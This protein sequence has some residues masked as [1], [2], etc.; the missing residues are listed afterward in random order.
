MFKNKKIIILGMARSGYEVAKLLAKY[1]NEITINDMNKDEDEKRVNELEKLGVEVILGS[2]PSNLIDS[3]IDYLIKNPGIHES[4][5]YVQKCRELG[6]PVLT[7]IEVAYHF[8]PQ[9]VFI[10]GI[11]GTNGKTTTTSLIYD[12]L[13][14]SDYKA[15]LAGNIGIPLSAMVQ[16][17]NSGDILVIEISSQQLINVDK[18]K[19]NIGI[20]TNLSE[21]HLDAH[22]TYEN[23][24][25]TKKKIFAHHTK[26]DIGIINFDNE[27][28]LELTEDIESTKKYFSTKE[29]KDAYLESNKIYIGDQ[30]FDIKDIKLI[31]KHNYENIMAALLV[32]EQLKI[33]SSLIKETLKEFGGVEHRMEFVR[34]INGI[35]FYNDSKSTNNVATITAL[36]S[37]K[38][39]TILIL[40]G[41]DR[42]I[43]FDELKEHMNHVIS[44]YCYGET[45]EKI[46][47]FCE[48]IN[49]K[50]FV[51]ETLDD[52]VINAYNY[53]KDEKIILFSPAC[54]SW[55]QFKNFE[56]R[57]VHF[58]KVVNNIE[59]TN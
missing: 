30:S 57:G 18:F 44:V 5:E 34:N 4:H 7:E 19:T 11:T 38:K 22:G 2:H 12:I 20:L 1:N 21:A 27:H 36:N 8:L 25:Y 53:S 48:S 3:S 59:K 56:I 40:G 58:K 28:C 10:I 23:Y 33:D 31:G 45:K 26:K 42:G 24:I 46:K 39:D 14:R 43:S 6:I 37:F 55:D 17:I 29:K 16:E 51:E 35:E 32:C 52:A 50:C 54:A 9:D 49:I 41:V 47:E 15:H 13:K